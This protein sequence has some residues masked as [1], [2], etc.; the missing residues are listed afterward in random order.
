MPAILRFAN[1]PGA[2]EP[3][4]RYSQGSE[5][6]GERVRWLHVSGQVAVAPDGSV[7][8]DDRVQVQLALDNLVAVLLGFGMG[9]GNIVKLNVFVTDASMVPIWREVR[10][11]AFALHPPPASTLL[12]VAG[13][14]SPAYRFEIEAVAAA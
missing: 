3:A 5:V 4:S 6:S 9:L 14:A 7:P 8:E 2:P 12:V 13:L 1:P 11:Q 10:D